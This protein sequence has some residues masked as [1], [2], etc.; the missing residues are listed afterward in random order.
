M[1]STIGKKIQCLRL[2]LIEKTP[3]KSKYYYLMV[4][5]GKLESL[6][7]LKLHKTKKSFTFGEDGVKFLL[8]AF[9]YFAKN[10]HKLEKL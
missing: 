6:K 8:K 7:T 5:I 2:N 10:G 3:F 1:T 9:K 4:I